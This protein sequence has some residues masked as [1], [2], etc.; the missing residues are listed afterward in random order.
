MQLS[1]FVVDDE[2]LLTTM[3]NHNVFRVNEDGNMFQVKVNDSVFVL[4]KDVKKIQ[5]EGKSPS[6][7]KK[8][9]S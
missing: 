3:S 5:V 7:Y 6:R 1:T 9:F 8:D 2:I 4:G